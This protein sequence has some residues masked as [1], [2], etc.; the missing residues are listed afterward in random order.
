MAFVDVDEFLLLRDGTPDM[1]TLLKDYEQYGGLVVNWVM[2]GS[3]GLQ[4]LGRARAARQSH[5]P[6]GCSLLPLLVNAAT[7]AVVS[8]LVQ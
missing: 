5:C 2:F 1:P 4:V 8:F 3:S 6:R 7:L